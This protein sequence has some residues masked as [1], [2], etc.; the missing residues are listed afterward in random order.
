MSSKS[1]TTKG[2]TSQAT[3]KDGMTKATTGARTPNVPLYCPYHDPIIR[4]EV[5][6]VGGHRQT[7]MEHFLA[8]D[9]PEQSAL[10]YRAD[11][12]KLSTWK[13]CLCSAIRDI[14]NGEEEKGDMVKG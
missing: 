4:L 1:S 9:P 14:I 10:F 11:T 7:P 6:T 8:E 13:G 3:S 2:T 12:G 5:Y